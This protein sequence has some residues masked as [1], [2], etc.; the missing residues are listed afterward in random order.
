M[1]ASARR[2]S[3]TLSPPPPVPNPARFGLT[4]AVASAALFSLKGVIVKLGLRDGLTVETLIA[5]RMALSL[6][7]YL[8]IGVIAFARPPAGDGQPATARRLLAAAALGVASYHV[9]TWLDFT[10]LRYVSAQLERLVLFTYPALTAVLATMFLREPFTRRHAVGLLLAYAGVACVFAF[11]LTEVGPDAARGVAFV[12]AAAALFAAYLVAARNVIRRLGGVRFTCVA[13]TAA[14][15]T[16]LL[17]RVLTLSAPAGL[18]EAA[19]DAPPV[20]LTR[21]FVYGLLLGGVATVVPSF[22][23]SA[24]VQRIGPARTSAAGNAGPAVTALAAVAVLGEPFG[25]PHAAGLVLIAAGVG[26]AANR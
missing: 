5:W 2:T 13:M 4:L 9:C 23:L 17:H 26:L 24:A 7:A 20:T 1:A 11:E 25:L 22:M 14:T 10:G 6:P 8:A 16:V 3:P 19:A 18:V 12:F 15:V 21:T